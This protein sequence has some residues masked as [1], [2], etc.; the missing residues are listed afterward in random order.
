MKLSAIVFITIVC[1][2][3]IVGFIQLNKLGN[4]VNRLLEEEGIFAEVRDP[5]GV[6][7]T[8]SQGDITITDLCMS[9][10]YRKEEP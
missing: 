9:L 1:I 4:Y 2:V 10:G 7:I 6:A 5:E 3:G 8:I